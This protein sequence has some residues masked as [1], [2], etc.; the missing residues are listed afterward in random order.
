MKAVQGLMEEHHTPARRSYGIR[1]KT[2]AHLNQNDSSERLQSLVRPE[3]GACSD[4]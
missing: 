4:I 2:L 1:G 3:D